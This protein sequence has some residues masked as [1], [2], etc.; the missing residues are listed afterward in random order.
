MSSDDMEPVLN[1]L[2]P[3]PSS[4]EDFTADRAAIRNTCEQ[5][6]HRT[7]RPA[8]SSQALKRRPQEGQFIT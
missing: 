7:L 1:D 6:T 3:L 5:S 8:S 2:L 4:V